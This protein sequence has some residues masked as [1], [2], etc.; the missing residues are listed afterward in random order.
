MPVR[1]PAGMSKSIFSMTMAAVVVE[2]STNG[3]FETRV[4]VMI[5]IPAYDGLTFNNENHMSRDRFRS[6]ESRLTKVT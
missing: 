5:V 3:G 1:A 2:Q 4:F 6:C